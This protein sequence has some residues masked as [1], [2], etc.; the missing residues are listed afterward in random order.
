MGNKKL[1]RL[2]AFVMLALLPATLISGEIR[3]NGGKTALKVTGSTYQSVTFSNTISTLQ[4]RDVE[5]K[6]GPFTELFLEGHGY[7]NEVGSPKLPVFRRLIEVP[8]GATFSIVITKQEYKEYECAA[9]GITNRIIP[10]QAPV[11]KGITD[12]ELIPFE[13]NAQAYQQNTL[14]GGTLVT[15]TPAG[16][17]RAVTLA[18]VDIA[19]VQY[20]PVTGKLRIYEKIEATVVF[21]GADVP[22]T[23]SMKN[24]LASPYFEKTY[25]LL[26]NYKP[27]TDQLITTSPVTYVIVSDPMFQQ[28]LQP[29]IHWKT[30]KGF[31]VIQAYTS[32]PNVGSTTTSIKAYLMGLYNNPPAGYNAPSFILFVGDVAQIPAWTNNGQATDLRYCEYTND[33]IPEVFYGRFSATSLSQLQPQIDKTLEYEQY[34]FPNEHFLDTC[35]MVAGADAA[36]QLTWGNGQINYGTTYYFNTAHNLISHTYLQPEPSGGNYSQN[37]RQ[38][39]SDGEC[40]SNY[41]AHGSENGWADPSFTIGNIAALQNDH[42]YPLMV[43]NCCLTSK[44]NVTCFAEELLRANGKGAIGYIGASNNSY[45]DEDY[46]WGC[47]FKAVST[48]PT[49]NPLH[50]GAYDVTFHDNGELTQDWFVTQGQMVV[51]GNMAVEE[52]STSSGSKLYY[53]EIYNLM[54]DPSL[55]IYFSVPPDL[56]A[57]YTNV[58]LMGTTTLNV[59]TEPYAYIGL[60]LNDTA[61]VAAQCA[62]SLGQAVLN[63]DAL[64]VP[65]YLDIVITKQNRKP[66]LDSIQVIP[67]SG[68]YLT[69][70]SF[71]VNDSLWGNNDHNADYDEAVQLDV[72]VTNLGVLTAYNLVS[73][74][75]TTDTNITITGNSFTF[76]SIPA[77]GTY[78]GYGAFTVTVKNNVADQH[79]TYCDVT[80][81]D[82]TD[83][84]TSTLILNLDA[85]QLTIGSITVTDPAPGGNNNGVLDPGESAT[86]KVTTVN[87]GHAPAGNGVAHLVVDPGS[88]PFIIVNNPDYYLGNLPVNGFIYA[89]FDVITNG[90][91]PIGTTVSLQYNETAGAANQYSAAK[92]YD[93]EIGQVPSYTITNGNATTCIANFFDTGGPD[94]NYVDNEDLTMTFY[95]ATTGAQLQV[96]FSAFEIE[97]ASGCSYDYLNIYDGANT[98]APLMGTWCGTDSPG[99]LVSSNSDGALTFMFHSDY[100]VNMAGWESQITC[101]GGPMTLLANAFPAQVCNGSSSQLTALVTGGTGTYTYQ[102]DPA[103]YLDDPESQT[104]VSTPGADITYTVTVNDGSATLTSSPIPVTLLP[105]PEPA[106]VIQTGNLLESS[107]ADGNQ[108]YLNG[109]M[110]PGANGQTYE[111]TEAGTYYTIITD[112]VTGCQSE[113]SNTSIIIGLGEQAAAAGVKIWPNPATDNVSISFDLVQGGTLRISVIDSY[114]REVRRFADAANV[115]AGPY[116]ATFST[117]SLEP[118]IYFCRIRTGEFT[119]IRKLIVSR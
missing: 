109:A 71:A 19:P 33:N 12:P 89:Y 31:R 35:T 106:V 98:L 47:G 119:T 26:A 103:T 25:R 88:T 8:V 80:F 118:G 99:T 63:F 43:G 81:T 10:A 51:G 64:T 39:V 57:S 13:F 46:W 56:T 91:T 105:V 9:A 44:Y 5:T 97:A 42:M 84:W 61:F 113:P 65:G 108:W 7:S 94:S 95:A 67:A 87:K 112:Q 73:T 3:L 49:Y 52:S 62:D 53:W 14:L 92:Q 116:S 40:Y 79:K 17:M 36:H 110:I 68:P 21:T 28:A 77:G 54:G 69:V 107:V 20:N 66:I 104:P 86:L 102:W 78:I 70:S 114:G 6:L 18:R 100:S 48:N 15:V 60:S 117:G 11:S 101:V 74:I 22:A 41:T 29:F 82:G 85:P 16:I 45:W 75:S 30:R 37:I 115:T 111:T 72:T 50:L 76:D 55:S 24:R 4:F 34:L 59:T 58:L 23:L 38:D 93:L 83:T 32:D 27:E 2:F 1:L 96:A 90:I